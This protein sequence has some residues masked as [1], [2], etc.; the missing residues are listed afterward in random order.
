VSVPL[1]WNVV[2][3]KE[4]IYRWKEY[5]EVIDW[6]LGQG[7]SV[8]AGPLIDF[9]AAQL[10]AWLWQWERDVPS[11]A[12]FMCRFVQAAVTRYRSK[13][14]RWQLTSASNCANL[15]GLGEDE[16]LGLTYRLV[17]TGRQVDPSLEFIVGVAQPWG[18]YM[19]LADRTHSPFIFA[20]TLIRSGLNLSAL[21]VELV[22]G[23]T[24]RGSYCRDML[25]ASRLL[26]LYA[27]LGVPLRVTLGY[28]SAEQS[29]PEAD[30]EMRVDAGRWGDGFTPQTQGDW[31]AAFTALALCKPPVQAVQWVHFSD[32]DPHQ[33]PHAGL[34][35]AG[36]PKPALARLRELREAHLR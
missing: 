27:L 36:Q 1:G 35:A 20:D 29:D 34:F 12:T 8:S 28:P 33:F 15:L 23:V 24:P 4:T 31:A 5:D 9:S 3:A 32:D 10:P 19:A 6:A 22:M 17:E 30:P 7:L 26:D 13:I 18:E 21:D 2:E 25:E 11:M 16:L 14:R